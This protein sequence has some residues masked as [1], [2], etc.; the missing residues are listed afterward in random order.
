[1]MIIIWIWNSI[2][3]SW[4]RVANP[5][6]R[7]RLSLSPSIHPLFF[8][9]HSLVCCTPCSEP[10]ISRMNSIKIQFPKGNT[11]IEM[12]WE[13]NGRKLVSIVAGQVLSGPSI[14]MALVGGYMCNTSTCVWFF[15]FELTSPWKSSNLIGRPRL[16]IKHPFI[17]FLSF[18]WQICVPNRLRCGKEIFVWPRGCFFIHSI[19]STLSWN[20]FP[21]RRPDLRGSYFIQ[22]EYQIQIYGPFSS[23]VGGKPGK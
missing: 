10:I 17:S 2:H 18:F 23:L 16:S 9:S 5:L 12:I 4:T 3:F 6:Y 22:N 20:W 14:S 15:S 8:L 7:S 19:P 1:M 21:S 13:G 11:I